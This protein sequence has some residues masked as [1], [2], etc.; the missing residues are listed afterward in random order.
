MN[1]LSLA[2]IRRYAPGV[3]SATDIRVIGEI[4]AVSSTMAGVLRRRYSLPLLTAASG[5]AAFGGIPADGDTVTVGD[6][7]YR[8]KDTPAA[9]ND[10]KRGASVALCEAALVA[11]LILDPLFLTSYYYTGTTPNGYCTGA[12]SGTTVTLTARKGGTE[13][14]SIPLSATGTAITVTAFSGGVG[15]Y[16]ALRMIG[17]NLVQAVLIRGQA[18]AAMETSQIRDAKSLWDLAMSQL[19]ALVGDDAKNDIWLT[20]DSGTAAAA[21]TN[22]LPTSSVADYSPE[23]GTEDPADWGWDSARDTSR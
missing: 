17:V 20:D 8:W 16:A 2:D 13:G 12:I 18:V 23:V 7:T 5:G 10:L 19:A 11:G 22:T 21:N 6:K 3:A 1:Y 9:I 4:E 14:N 15:S